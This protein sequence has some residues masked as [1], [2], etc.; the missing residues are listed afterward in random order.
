[1]IKLSPRQEQ[2]LGL[3]LGLFMPLLS[4]YLIFVF[5]P[6][7]LGVQ[8]FNYEVIKQL[9]IGLLTFGMLLNAACF[10][11]LLRFEKE[12]LGNGILQA[13]VLL[14]LLMVIYKFML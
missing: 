12:R 10:F 13:T 5:R 6:E 7:Y 2:V 1:M 11:L 3:L 4:L 14:L 9:N 8:K